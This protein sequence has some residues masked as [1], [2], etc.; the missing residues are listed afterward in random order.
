MSADLNAKTLAVMVVNRVDDAAADKAIAARKAKLKKFAANL[1][2]GSE[3]DTLKKNL[4]ELY[5]S[6]CIFAEFARSLPPSPGR[7]KIEK[8]FPELFTDNKL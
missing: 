7:D 2:H 3:R 1:P 5:S 4:P 8:E 6:G